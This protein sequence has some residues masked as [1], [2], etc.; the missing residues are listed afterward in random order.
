MYTVIMRAIA[1][2]MVKALKNG[3]GVRLGRASVQSSNRPRISCRA[4]RKS[5]DDGSKVTSDS[6]SRR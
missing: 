2:Y 3:S 4:S 5:C 1:P 6:S